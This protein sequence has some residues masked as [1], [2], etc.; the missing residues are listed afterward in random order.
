MRVGGIVIIFSGILLVAHRFLQGRGIA[1]LLVCFF[2]RLWKDWIGSK[3]AAGTNLSDTN[4][5]PLESNRVEEPYLTGRLIF[6]FS[7]YNNSH[8]LS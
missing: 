7:Y 6:N 8:M 2:Y 4:K 1:H 3:D 5:A